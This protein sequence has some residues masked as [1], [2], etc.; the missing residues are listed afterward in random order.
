MH[1]TSR[2]SIDSRHCVITAAIVALAKTGGSRR[3]REA[4]MMCMREEAE[5]EADAADLSDSTFASF[6]SF[7]IC[8]CLIFSF[9]VCALSS[10]IGL[11]GA[12]TTVGVLP[13]LSGLTGQDE[14]ECP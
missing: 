6:S 9:V 8:H 10:E 11:A 5:S 7:V 13:A 4:T 3:P 1:F 2:L 12:V 14:A